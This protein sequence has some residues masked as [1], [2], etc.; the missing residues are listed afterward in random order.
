VS[1]E[2]RHLDAAS[3]GSAVAVHTGDGDSALQLPEQENP[4]GGYYVVTSFDSIDREKLMVLVRE[5]ISDRKVLKLLRKWLKAGVMEDG[6]V[7]ETLA[8][9]PQGGVITPRTQKVTSSF[10]GK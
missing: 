8:G 2:A 4:G 10:P 7:R 1:I 3:Q 6:T 9:T 5:R